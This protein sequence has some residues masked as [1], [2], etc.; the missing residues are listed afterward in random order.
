LAIKPKY[1]WDAC[2][3]IG[4]IRQEPD[5]I[6]SLRYV[7]EMA[8]KG[9]VEIW[10]SAFT[11]AEVFKR[12]CAGEQ[13]GLEPTEDTAFEDYLE[14]DYVQRVQVD[15]DVG[16]AA[17]RLLRRFPQIRKPQD[18]VHAATAALHSVDELHTFDGDDLLPMDGLIPMQNGQKLKICKPPKPPEVPDPYRGTMFEGLEAS[19]TEINDAEKR[20]SGSDAGK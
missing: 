10:T 6:D 1:Y 13:V 9:Q 2:A 14:Q 19:V 4:L 16:T 3:W 8:Q 17:R 12:K 7:I 5:K 18:A 20:A 11:L 15:V